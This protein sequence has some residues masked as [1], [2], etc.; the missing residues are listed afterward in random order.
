MDIVLGF[1]FGGTKVAIATA[2]EENGTLLDTA[3][4]DSRTFP[5]GRELVTAAIGMG[6][7]LVERAYAKVSSVRLTS[8][9]VSTMGVTYPDRVEMAPNVPG[10]GE[11]RMPEMFYSAFDGIRLAIENDVKAAALAEVRKG[12][13]MGVDVGMYLNLGTGI[14]VALTIG[15]KVLTGSHG[16]AGEIA[17]C[18]M[19]EHTIAGFQEGVAPFEEFVG[20]IWIERRARETF[21]RPLTPRDILVQETTSDI[22]RFRD[23]LLS[24]LAFQLTN[25]LIL[26]DPSRLVVGGGMSVA[27]DVLFPFLSERFHRYV[28]YPPEIQQA[29][30]GSEAGL[31][32]AIELARLSASRRG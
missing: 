13:L 27:K 5:D 2:V 10:W 32:G 1:D 21:G 6:Q 16:A 9:G 24:T 8:I 19:H 25:A 31:I 7:G 20:G 22:A 11:L 18:L 23:E 26:W 30:F 4:L 15:D 28:P 12:A 29:K 3:V 14:A 17:Y